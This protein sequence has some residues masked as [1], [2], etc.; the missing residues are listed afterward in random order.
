MD[1]IAVGTNLFKQGESLPVR[2]GLNDAPEGGKSYGGSTPYTLEHAIF[3]SAAPPLS[4][5]DFV[6][7]ASAPTQVFQR[8]LIVSAN[9]RT[10]DDLDD[11]PPLC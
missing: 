10:W 11:E 5:Q 4:G 1:L 2:I 9:T 8:E 3:E 7:S 6:L